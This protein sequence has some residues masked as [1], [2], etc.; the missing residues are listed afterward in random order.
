L[1]AN[2]TTSEREPKEELSERPAPLVQRTLLAVLL[3]LALESYW[4]LRLQLPLDLSVAASALVMLTALV[5]VA[6]TVT[7]GVFRVCRLLWSRQPGWLF[8]VLMSPWAWLTADALF[9]GKRIGAQSGVVFMKLGF[10]AALV[11]GCRFAVT[12]A[13]WVAGRPSGIQAR[14]LGLSLCALLVLASYADNQVQVGLYPAFHQ[15]VGAATLLAA[16]LL[17]RLWAQRRDLS[18]PAGAGA[19]ARL[20]GSGLLM[21]LCGLAPWWGGDSAADSLVTFTNGLL[22]KARQASVLVSGLMA[23]KADDHGALER[24]SSAPPPRNLLEDAGEFGGR[25]WVASGGWAR[26]GPGRWAMD[27]SAAVLRQELRREAVCGLP[28]VASVRVRRWDPEAAENSDRPVEAATSGSV[29][30][31]IDDPGRGDRRSM[32][33][34]LSNQWI[35]LELTLEDT[36][37]PIAAAVARSEQDEHAIDASS[38]QPGQGLA[39][40]VDVP[41]RWGHLANN[42]QQEEDLLPLLLLED[43][44]ELGPVC[45]L[46]RTIRAEGGGAYSHWGDQL[47]FSTSDGSDPRS[48]G[49]SYSLVDPGY[50]TGKP[51]ERSTLVVSLSIEGAEPG[52]ELEIDGFSAHIELPDDPQQLALSLASEFAF[53]ATTAPGIEAVRSATRNVILLILD[54]VREDHVGPDDDGETLTPHLDALSAE[55]IKFSTTYSPSDQ[56]GRSVPSLVTGLPLQVTLDAAE[57]GVPLRTFMGRLRAAGLSTFTNGSN[58]ILTKYKHIPIE[59]GFGAQ[60]HGSNEQKSETLA[61]EVLAHVESLDGEPFA[62]YAHW[63]YAHVWRSKDMPGDYAREVSHADEKVGQ[64]VAGLKAAGVW[65]STLLIVTADHGY[66]LGESFRYQGAQG[67]AERSLRVPLVMHVPGLEAAGVV[68]TEVVSLLALVPTIFDALLPDENALVSDRSLFSLILDDNDPRRLTGG[69]AFSDMGFSFMTRRAG[70]KLSEDDSLRTAILF[71][72]ESDPDDRVPLRETESSIALQ[73]LRKL[74]WERQA[75]LSQA[76]IVAH[77]GQLAPEVLLAFQKRNGAIEDVGSVIER[78]WLYNPVSR[79]FLFYQILSRGLRDVG[80]SL[81][82]IVRPG[83]DADDQQL[84]VMRAWASGGAALV[85]LEQRYAELDSAARLCLADLLPSIDVSEVP[86]LVDLIQ[87]DALGL[88]A[89]G[90]VPG[91]LDE[92]RIALALTGVAK[93]KTAGELDQVKDCLVELFNSWMAAGQPGPYFGCLRMRK[94]NARYLLDV[95]RDKPVPADLARADRLLRNRCFAERIPKMCLQLDSDAARAWL[96]AELEQWVA[97]DEVLPGQF[98]TAVIPI[99][100]SY[101]ND[102][103]RCEADRVIQSRFP[104]LQLIDG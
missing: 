31:S 38:V 29:S 97:P 44:N 13:R 42:A 12:L 67:C 4:A 10:A 78:T 71:A 7:L 41:E 94:F 57:H 104:Y 58:Y 23:A 79:A 36:S 5:L 103:F 64:L 18:R 14:R 47:I 11:L 30:L 59:P 68:L 88:W 60:H 17:A 8:A 24:S 37:T 19:T 1:A 22:P 100:R 66:S 34:P 49:R 70:F 21:L 81:D 84:L 83:F 50:L 77:A 45:P 101:D 85:E 87:A 25:A 27:G 9:S 15:A 48:N 69:T 72:P 53:A 98:L 91:S 73:Q 56:T 102:E 92:R 86:R 63:S 46:H 90:V 74:E 2:V 62:V 35:D 39:W 65:D 75:R 54:A 33:V 52:C 51:G 93:H 80:P 96:L 16:C 26:T 95:F 20:M 28:L 82:A 99:L 76:L 55:G 40:T 89:A 43:G 32:T 3:L 61:D 6:D